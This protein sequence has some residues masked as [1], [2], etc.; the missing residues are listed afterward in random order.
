VTTT[1]IVNTFGSC[2]CNCF[3]AEQK[4]KRIILEV[5][6]I[7][8]LVCLFR[9]TSSGDGILNTTLLAAQSIEALR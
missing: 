1:N 8:S 3:G 9:S 5:I 2:G 6:D 4:V 7:F